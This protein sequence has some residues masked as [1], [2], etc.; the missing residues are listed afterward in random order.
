MKNYTLFTI[1]LLLIYSC[2]KDTDNNFVTLLG[3]IE[4]Y[5]QDSIIVFHPKIE[6]RKVIRLK[7]DGTFKDTLK[8]KNGL[9]SYS[10]GRDFTSLYLEN[11]DTL[12]INYNTSDFYKTLTFDGNHK[13]ENDFLATSLQKENDF[14]L[15]TKLM[16]LPKNEFDSII[17]NYVDDFNNRLNSTTLDPSFKTFETNE[18]ENFKKYVTNSYLKI[19]YN[20]LVL[21]TGKQS[22]EFVNYKNFDGSTTS[23][24]DLKG[25]YAYIDIWATWCKPCKDEIPFLKDLEK[26]YEGKSINFVSISVDSERDFETWKKMVSD[27][28]MGGIQLFTNGDTKFTDAYKIISI[29]RFILLD[30]EGRIINSNAPRASNPEIHKVFDNLNL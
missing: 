18:I 9:F 20:K 17:N 12:E 25:K 13:I 10:D 16:K 24:S 14:L 29:P 6:Y 19:N 21:G 15:D 1:L 2:Q 22:P 8:V 11:G 26:K 28:Q 5:K 27:K 7:E 23:L 4:N 30:Q 3:K